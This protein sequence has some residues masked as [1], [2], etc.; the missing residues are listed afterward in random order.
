MATFS[1]MLGADKAPFVVT[2]ALGMLGWFLTTIITNVSDVVILHISRQAKGNDTFYTLTNVSIKRSLSNAYFLF[3]CQNNDCL[4][5]LSGGNYII[6]ENIPPY[7]IQGN[8]IC[9]KE[10]GS[11]AVLVSLPSGGAVRYQIKPK[12]GTFPSI[13][14]VG[15]SK[16][17][18]PTTRDR[19]DTES[20]WIFE[21]CSLLVFF[22][23]YYLHILSFALLVS[24]VLL[25]YLVFRGRDDEGQNAGAGEATT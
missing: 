10:A 2:L 3:N 15:L 8:K 16:A 14:F 17:D 19:L 22:A 5:D 1:R 21:G 7:A 25:G 18:C 23:K 24:S 6:Q 9:S 12:V 20:V 4:S 13:V 11:A